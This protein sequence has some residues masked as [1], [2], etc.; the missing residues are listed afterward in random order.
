MEP[1][2]ELLPHPGSCRLGFASHKVESFKYKKFIQTQKEHVGSL[3]TGISQ[4]TERPSVSQVGQLVVMVKG[5]EKEVVRKVG[6][7]TVK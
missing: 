6:K 1:L 7:G 2:K 3:A 5:Q 4:Q